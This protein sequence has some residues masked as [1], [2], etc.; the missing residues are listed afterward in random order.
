MLSIPKYQRIVLGCV[1]VIAVGFA[2]YFAGRA[3]Q[4]KFVDMLSDKTP[5]PD[6]KLEQEGRYEE[7]IQVLLSPNRERPIQPEDYSRV[8]FL[9]LEWAKKDSGNRVNLAHKSASYSEKS[10]QMAP[11]DPFVLETALNNLDRAGD[12]LED[13]CPYYLEAQTIGEKVLVLTEKETVNVR[14]M[15]YPTQQFKESVPYFLKTVRAKVKA[16]CNKP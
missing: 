14:G 4:I 1:S 9:Y 5:P 10:V 11:S 2:G 13:G 8:A 7:A 15:S 16:W 3:A 12:Y 6:A